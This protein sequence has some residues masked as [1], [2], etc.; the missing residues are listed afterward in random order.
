MR[1]LLKYLSTSEV[2]C[3][4]RGVLALDKSHPVNDHFK[5]PYAHKMCKFPLSLVFLFPP[6][7][8]KLFI[9]I[10]N[11]LYSRATYLLIRSLYSEKY[12]EKYLKEGVDQLV[13][14]GSGF[15]SFC[16]RRKNI[17]ESADVYELDLPGMQK[18]K[19][20]RL[21]KV[22]P[23][24]PKRLLFVE[25]NLTSLTLVDVLCSVKF[26]RRRPVF[27]S[28]LGVSYYIEKKLFIETLK[29]MKS[30]SSM[31]RIIAFDYLIG[32][33]E[34][35]KDQINYKKYIMKHQTDIG[36]PM[37][38]DIGSKELNFLLEEQGF[39]IIFNESIDEIYNKLFDC[40]PHP[41]AKPSC[42]AMV[43]C[44]IKEHV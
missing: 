41:S 37:I 6:Y 42:Y 19:I 5:D 21:Y 24:F 23:K 16:L 8:V 7:T 14:I 15:D 2:V 38:F 36:E 22:I 28:I 44:Q 27:F 35:N 25:Y 34:L 18:D 9:S 33:N 1:F 31:K 32:D 26:D 29:L 39:E 3:A 17:F 12:F 11:G 20:N 30:S 4:L 13:F 40:H 43:I 10:Y